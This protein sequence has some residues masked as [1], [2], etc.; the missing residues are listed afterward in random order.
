M[1]V[2]MAGFEKVS[3]CF[4][5]SL[6]LPESCNQFFETLGG[7]KLQVHHEWPSGTLHGVSGSRDIFVADGRRFHFKRKRRVYA[8][9]SQLRSL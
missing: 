8:L 5:L 3:P 9:A 2:S 6:V 1:T 4:T 7:F